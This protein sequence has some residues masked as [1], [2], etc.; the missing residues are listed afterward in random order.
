M[1]NAFSSPTYLP[2]SPQTT[3]AHTIPIVSLASH[4]IHTS[5]SAFSLSPPSGA[6]PHRDRG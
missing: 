3:K 2:Y 4:N 1:A 5:A 6:S